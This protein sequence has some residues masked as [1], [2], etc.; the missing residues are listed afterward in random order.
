[1]RRFDRTSRNANASSNYG[2][3]TE[4]QHYMMPGSKSFTWRQEQQ[5]QCLQN[6]SNLTAS[7][8][9]LQHE[10]PQYYERSFGGFDPVNYSL[11]GQHHLLTYDTQMDVDKDEVGMAEM[12][13]SQMLQGTQSEPSVSTPPETLR[14]DLQ[15]A[16]D[17][18]PY[19]PGPLD[20]GSTT[21]E[22]PPFAM[23]MQPSFSPQGQS[24]SK[25]Q[26]PPAQPARNLAT[27]NPSTSAKAHQH[28]D[29]SGINMKKIRSRDA[30]ARHDAARLAP[31]R[32]Q[33]YTQRL[34]TD[35][36]NCQPQLPTRIYETQI[37][38]Q[39][40]PVNLEIGR[41]LQPLPNIAHVEA[42]HHAYP[43]DVDLH[44]PQGVCK[45]VP[46]YAPDHFENPAHSAPYSPVFPE[47]TQP[48]GKPAE[49]PQKIFVGFSFVL[50]PDGFINTG[51]TDYQYMK[52]CSKR[53]RMLLDPRE[54]YEDLI[55]RVQQ[56]SE[57]NIIEPMR[58]R[59]WYI[60]ELKKEMRRMKKEVAAFDG[61]LF[62]VTGAKRGVVF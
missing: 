55:Q 18:E 1:M 60:N 16:Y 26:M 2:R 36:S 24:A 6:P 29:H 20:L 17:M 9:M 50:M 14:N 12:V 39:N 15:E 40:E 43:D 34:A 4:F 19:I 30:G 21:Y 46:N 25:S 57:L 62:P 59:A 58:S 53:Q 45:Y 52:L 5:Q 49:E 7:D 42:Q 3:H 38:A 32:R 33:G 23:N 61:M 51:V 37:T 11:A 35:V 10:T 27:A 8:G 13:M 41:S 47:Y 44:L 31:K 28:Q 22:L 48:I 56:L 54:K